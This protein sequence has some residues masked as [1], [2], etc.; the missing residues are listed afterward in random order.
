[1]LLAALIQINDD[2][3]G[4]DKNDVQVT[5]RM[6]RSAMANDLIDLAGELA[7]IARATTDEQTGSR[8][9]EFSGP[10]PYGRGS[11]A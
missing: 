1:M 10:N 9:M 5:E 11:V 3:S 8:L 7:E 2:R 4:W 6:D